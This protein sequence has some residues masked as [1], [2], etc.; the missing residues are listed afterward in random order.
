MSDKLKAQDSA[1]GPALTGAFNALHGHERPG[2]VEGLLPGG[3]AVIGSEDAGGTTT[4]GDDD[5]VVIVEARD[6]VKVCE[7]TGAEGPECEQNERVTEAPRRK[8]ARTVA[9]GVGLEDSLPCGTAI[10]AAGDAGGKR[11]GV[12]GAAVLRLVN[13]P[14]RILSPG[15]IFLD[16]DVLGKEVKAL[17]L[18]QSNAI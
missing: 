2:R 12:L 14:V 9:S 16:V 8:S 10:H 5:T 18:L 3:T 13:K 11:V 4:L 7:A 6:L 1:S 17:V 15:G